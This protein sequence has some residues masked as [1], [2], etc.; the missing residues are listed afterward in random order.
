MSDKY[1]TLENGRK[2]LKEAINQSSGAVDSGKIIAADSAGRLDLSLMPVG[3]APDVRILETTEDLSAGSYVNIYESAGTFFCRLADNSN[4][5]EA[6]G[7]VKDS[8]LTAAN[9]TIYFEGENSGLS[10]LVNGTVYLGTSGGVIQTPLNEQTETGKFHQ[11]LGKA[12]SDT[13]VNTDIDEPIEL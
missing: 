9:A 13:A 8:F 4:Q 6:N 1:Q 2:K 7:Y 11:V 12:V 5:R 10:G 3:I